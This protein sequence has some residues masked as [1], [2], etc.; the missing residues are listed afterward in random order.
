MRVTEGAGG[1]GVIE[2]VVSHG[3][4]GWGSR[5]GLGGRGSWRGRLRVTE[6]AGGLGVTEEAGGLGV[7]EGTVAGGC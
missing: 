4:G 5:R 3:G 1:L 6:G 2:E 7:M